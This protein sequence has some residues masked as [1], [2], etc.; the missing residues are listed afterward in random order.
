MVL[1]LQCATVGDKDKSCEVSVFKL[2]VRGNSNL[3]LEPG[4][5]P[6]SRSRQVFMLF[7]F[8]KT[9][10]AVDKAENPNISQRHSVFTQHHHQ[11]TKSR[12]W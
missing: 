12:F 4:K 2:Q 8:L 11:W 7:F 10:K 9:C 1:E 3:Q 5:P 6:R